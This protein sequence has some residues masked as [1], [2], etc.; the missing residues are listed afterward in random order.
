MP[1]I[2]IGLALEVQVIWVDVT[3]VLPK[4][5]LHVLL[6]CQNLGS[7]CQSPNVTEYRKLVLSQTWWNRIDVLWQKQKD[8]TVGVHSPLEQHW[9]I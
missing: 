6:V 3:S 7:S 9:W 1:T 4:L 8:K 5:S 2:I